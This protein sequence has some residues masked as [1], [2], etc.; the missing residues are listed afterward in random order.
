MNLQTIQQATKGKF[1]ARDDGVFVELELSKVYPNPEQPRKEFNNIDELAATIKEDGLLQPIVV[2]KDEDGRYMVIA[3][4]RRYRACSSLS[5]RTIKAHVIKVSSKR[6][7]E[8]SLVENIQRDDLT[9]FEK[10]Q[11]INKLWASGHYESKKELAETIGKSQSYLSKAFK[12]VKLC[13]EIVQDLEENKSDIGLEVLQELSNIK[14]KET[15]LKLYLNKA[16]REEIRNYQK[17]PSLLE[18]AKISPAK[19]EPIKVWEIKSNFMNDDGFDIK[20]LNHL[21]VYLGANLPKEIDDAWDET[22]RYKI[23][24][25]EI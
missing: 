20:T 19:K 8:L 4:E 21:S 16:T 12:A 7:Q 2:T 15:Q 22:K 11:F 6:V 24:I 13:N 18:E 14:D 10:A 5:M 1:D 9:D 17:T 23:T 25:E 3:G